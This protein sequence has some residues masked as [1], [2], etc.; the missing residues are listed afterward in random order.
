MTVLAD[1]DRVRILDG[2][3]VL[4]EHRRS[5]DKA[6]QIE[7]PA[8]VAALVAHKRG[9]RHHHASDRLAHAAPAS[10]DLLQR[11]AA[12]GDNLGSITAA[13]GRLLDRYGAQPLQAAILVALARDVP[14][15][16]AVR[17]A[18]EYAREQRNQPPPVVLVLSAP[19]RARDVLVRTHA[20]ASYD[21]LKDQLNQ[22]PEELPDE[23]PRNDRSA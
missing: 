11:A 10:A 8:H 6:A 15:P 1:L 16:N 20:L 13:L 7:D 19:V 3:N 14:H 4:A 22:S 9:A 5:Y 12:R 2:E 23:D 18:L 17:L 21:A